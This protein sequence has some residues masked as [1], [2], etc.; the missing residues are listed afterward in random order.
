LIKRS[1]VFY[2]CNTF[3]DIISV[4]GGYFFRFMAAAGAAVRFQQT[5]NP[6]GPAFYAFCYYLT[7][8]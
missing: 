7:E 3:L 4:A 2:F 8:K 1:L 5:G 6:D